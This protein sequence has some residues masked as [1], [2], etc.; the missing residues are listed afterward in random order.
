V[1]IADLISSTQAFEADR[2]SRSKTPPRTSSAVSIAAKHIGI[3]KPAAYKASDKNSMTRRAVVFT[4]FAKSDK[5]R[6]PEAEWAGSM[7]GPSGGG[8]YRVFIFVPQ[9]NVRPLKTSGR[10]AMLAKGK[11]MKP[12]VEGKTKVKVRC[13]CSDFRWRFAYYDAKINALYGAAPPPYVKKSN[14]PPVNPKG[15]PGVCKHIMAAF[16]KMRQEGYLT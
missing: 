14:R 10:N 9:V 12:L 16:N 4:Y 3:F 11:Y 13:D 7:K 15:I 2:K 1:T 8:D 5:G 6:A